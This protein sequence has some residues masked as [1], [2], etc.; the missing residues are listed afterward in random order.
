MKSVNAAQHLQ[1]CACAAVPYYCYSAFGAFG[2]RVFIVPEKDLMILHFGLATDEF[3]DGY[4]WNTEVGTYLF[5]N[6]T[7]AIG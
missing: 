7:K 6:I 1:V 3:Q 4:I 5:G 2:Q